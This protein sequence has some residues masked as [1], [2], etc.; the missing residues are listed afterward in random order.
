MGGFNNVAKS[1]EDLED[2]TPEV[3]TEEVKVE[4]VQAE[5]TAKDKEEQE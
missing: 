5:V 2:E 3:K 4:E 1:F